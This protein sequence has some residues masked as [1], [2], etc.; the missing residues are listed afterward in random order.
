MSADVVIQ[1]NRTVVTSTLKEV[2]VSDP[3][4]ETKYPKVKFTFEIFYSL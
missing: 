3:N 2:T 4:T 1:D